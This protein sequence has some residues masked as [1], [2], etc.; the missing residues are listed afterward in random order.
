LRAGGGIDRGKDFI[1]IFFT[2]FPQS[3]PDFPSA[4]SLLSNVPILLSVVAPLNLDGIRQR[5]I[6]VRPL[7]LPNHFSPAARSAANEC[8]HRTFFRHRWTEK[9]VRPFPPFSL[10]AVAL[11]FLSSGSGS[12]DLFALKLTVIYAA[13]RTKVAFLSNMILYCMAVGFK[14]ASPPI[15]AEHS[16]PR[17]YSTFLSPLLSLLKVPPG[18]PCG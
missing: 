18:V 8:F 2:E 6:S 11:F 17:K 3:L 12:R 15:K 16:H 5:Q 1:N 14:K 7:S 13:V 4:V 9:T 10:F